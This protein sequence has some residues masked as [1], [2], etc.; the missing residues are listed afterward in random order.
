MPP[1]QF[2]V[3]VDFDGVI[4]EYD[5]WKGPD[6]LGAPINGASETLKKMRDKGWVIVIFTTRL[7]SKQLKEYLSVWNIP[8][9][10]INENPEQYP[11]TNKGKPAANVYID[12]RAINFGGNWEETLETV[13]N[14][15]PWYNEHVG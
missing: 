7:P 5:G 12:D 6:I 2:T 3:C 14:F 10:Y 11:N 4:A 13:E 1:R 9:D 15:K 8:Y